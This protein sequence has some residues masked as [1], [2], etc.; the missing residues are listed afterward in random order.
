MI[1]FVRTASNLIQDLFCEPRL[2]IRLVCDGLDD[3]YSFALAASAEDE[4][5]A[6][7]EVEQ[8]EAADVPGLI[9]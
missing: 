4:L 9:S 7:E 3:G 1:V 8:E 6:F 2:D 5:R